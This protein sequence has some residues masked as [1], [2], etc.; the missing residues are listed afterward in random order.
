NTWFEP[1][2]PLKTE[3][4]VLTI[5]VPSQFFYEWLEEHYV[6]TIKEAIKQEMGKD[7]RLEYSVVVENS[8]NGKSGGTSLKINNLADRDGSKAKGLNP[9]FIEDLKSEN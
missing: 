1:I 8:E 5:Q 2:K 9:S 4:N 3:G 7:A 6:H